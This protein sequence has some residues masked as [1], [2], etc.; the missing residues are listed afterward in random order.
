MNSY[1][2]SIIRIHI[3]AFTYEFIYHGRRKV[4]YKKSKKTKS[5]PPK[6]KTRKSPV[7]SSVS[8]EQ[9]KSNVVTVVNGTPKCLA[10]PAFVLVNYYPKLGDFT[11]EWDM[12]NDKREGLHIGVLHFNNTMTST[13]CSH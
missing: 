1:I 9:R 11:D 4:G 10:L 7:P 3:F 8:K 6:K 12:V 13:F 2:L 5:P